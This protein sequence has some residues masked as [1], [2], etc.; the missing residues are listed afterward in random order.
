[1][2]TKKQHDVVPLILSV[3]IFSLQ[4][5]TEFQCLCF[6]GQKFAQMEEKIFVASLMRKFHVESVHKL[7]EMMPVGELVLHP[8]RGLWVKL[9][10]RMESMKMNNR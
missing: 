8:E 3:S 7:E 9:T 5:K 6:S 10:P 2:L 1:V 4:E